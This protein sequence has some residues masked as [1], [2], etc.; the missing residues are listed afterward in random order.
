MG[1][2]WMRAFERYVGIEGMVTTV[3]ALDSISPGKI[4]NAVGGLMRI[5]MCFSEVLR[6]RV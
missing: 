6:S 1:E 2:D 3:S 5:I 4:D